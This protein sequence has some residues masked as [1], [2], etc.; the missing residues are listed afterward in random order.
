MITWQWQ[1]I[2]QDP[3]QPACRNALA[4]LSLAK[5]VTRYAHCVAR[6]VR[7]MQATHKSN[8]RDFVIVAVVVV[9]VVSG[10]TKQVV[11]IENQYIT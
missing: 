4:H 9:V 7:L 11:M 10:S 6:C 3:R 8:G 5:P 2:F 1:D